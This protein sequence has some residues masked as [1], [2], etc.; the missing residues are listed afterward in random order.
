MKRRRL[1]RRRLFAWAG[2]ALAG[3]AAPATDA[4]AAAEPATLLPDRE[5][6]ARAPLM[7]V[8]ERRF[9]VYLYARLNRPKAA[10]QL[11][12]TVLAANP[13]DRQTLLVLASMYLE[14]QDAAATL[15]TARRFLAAYPD[16]HQGLYFLASGHYLAREYAASDRLFRALQEKPFPSGRFPYETDL[17]AAAAAAGDW[18]AAMLAYQR[19][20]RSHEIGE[21]L[22]A[23]VRRALDGIYREHLPRLEVAGAQ[24]RLDRAEVQR[25]TVMHG[26]HL[27]DRQWLEVRYGRDG[28]GLEDAPGLVAADRVRE[29]FAAHHSML[30]DG[31]WRTEAWLGHSGAGA[32]GGARVNYT[33]AR[34]RE[35][36][37]EATA[38]TRATDSLTLEALD[39]RQHQLAAVL[40]WLIEADLTLIVRLQRRELRVGGEPLGNTGGAELNLDLT[41]RRHDP[42]IVVGYRGSVSRFSTD[43]AFP[44]VVTLPIA[45]P[46][47]GIAAQQ[48]I[49]ANLVSRRIN[50]HGTGLLITDNLAR[51]WVYR[52]TAGV[53]YDF[54]LSTPAWNAALGLGF[55][56]RKSLELNLEGGYTSSASA[57]NAGS[58]AA[59]LNASIRYHF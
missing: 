11:A 25:S 31:R 59:L 49:A 22:R 19:L 2:L 21:E 15:R 36:A 6:L 34:Q 5:V 28:V 10:E 33:V 47:G 8:E 29:E 30:H 17:A 13:A 45:D 37:L 4:R 3:T 44:S 7:S 20:L 26:R 53:D 16:D 18:F 52:L 42:R 46:Q 1:L 41:L 38:N 35:L 27:N 57:S 54:E 43:P 55:F 9:L 39:G 50:R 58:G 12:E 40:S 32:F 51:A 14:Q 24:V 56:P 48:A 23:N